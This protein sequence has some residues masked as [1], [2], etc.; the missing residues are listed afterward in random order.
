MAIKKGSKVMSLWK[1]MNNVDEPNDKKDFENQINK[2]T[3]LFSMGPFYYFVMNMADINIEFVSKGIQNILGISPEDFN[4]QTLF[5]LYH[6]ED[7]QKLHEKEE[8]IGDF[9]YN[10]TTIKGAFAYKSVYLKRLRHSNGSYKTILHQAMALN[11]SD[12]GKLQQSLVIQTDVTHL[13]IPVDHKVSLIAAD[14]EP[15]YYAMEKGVYFNL[16]E[17]KKETAFTKRELEIIRKMSEGLDF[18]EIGEQLH[19]SPHTVRA[20]KRN[21]FKKAGCKNSAQLITKCIREGV[22]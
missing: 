21:I 22:I 8:I 14:G 13:N 19:I 17:T 6:P 18:N 10:Q 5:S 2:M 3:F 20:H 16:D 12:D 1:S 11:V 15:S 7:F 4:L 9:L